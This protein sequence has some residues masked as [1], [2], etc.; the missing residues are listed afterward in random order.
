[1][2]RWGRITGVLPDGVH[3]LVRWYGDSH[4][5]VVLPTENARAARPEHHPRN[6]G[7]AVGLLP[8]A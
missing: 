5:T 7:D 2:W 3:L 4:D 1:M 8:V 6:A